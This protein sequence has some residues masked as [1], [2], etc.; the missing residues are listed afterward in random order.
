MPSVGRPYKRRFRGADYRAPRAIAIAFS[1]GS[2]QRRPSCRRERKIPMTND[3]V[4]AGGGP[5]GLLLACELGLAGIRSTVLE[6]LPG[7]RAEPR[8]NGLV[9][10]VIRMLDRRGLYERITGGAAPP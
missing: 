1:C 9:G 3:V 8:A 7:E 10:Q 2:P 5:N 4:I 6:E